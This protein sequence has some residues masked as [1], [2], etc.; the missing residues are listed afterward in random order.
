MLLKTCKSKWVTP[1]TRSS[2]APRG[3]FSPSMKVSASWSS[4]RSRPWLRTS[5][6]GAGP[7]GGTTARRRRLG[8][9][10]SNKATSDA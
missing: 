7:I 4:K 2:T 5:G 9:I 3:V 10:R 8:S 1:G 6:R